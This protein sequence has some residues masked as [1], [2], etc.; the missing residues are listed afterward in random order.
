VN[1][2]EQVFKVKG[3]GHNVTTKENLR[4]R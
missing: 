2:A 1:N 3:Q 4:T